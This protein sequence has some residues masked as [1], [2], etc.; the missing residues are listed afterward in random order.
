MVVARDRYVAE[1]AVGRIVVTYETLPPVVGIATRPS[2]RARRARGHPRQRRGRTW[3]R[4]SAT[5]TRRSPAAPHVL[6]L[7]LDF[8]RSASTPMEGKGVYARWD[9]EDSSLRVYS[10]TQASTSVRAAIAAKLEL[11]LNKVECIA[12]DVGGG[13][14]VKIVHPWPEEILV[15]WA[16]RRL[17]PSSR[18]GSSG[19]RTAASTSSRRRTSAASCSTCGSASTTTAACSASTSQVWHDN[20]AYTPYGIIVPIITSTQLLGPYKPRCLPLPG[21]GRS[22]PTP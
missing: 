5:S 18:G 10:S 16:A 1:D 12:P 4:R 21:R 3:S 6:E 14:G 9:V 13:F 2:G 20:G 11:S 7:D 22:T 19:P 8:S 17:A 15:S